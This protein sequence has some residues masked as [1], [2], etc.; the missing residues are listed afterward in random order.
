MLSLIIGIVLVSIA[1]ISKAIMDKLQFHYHKC[2]FKI[3]PVK[4]DQKF[5]DPTLSWE[6][7]YKEGSMIEPKFLGSTTYFVFLTDAWHFFQMIMLLS[8]FIGISLTAYYSGSIIYMIIKVIVL[9]SFFG[10]S[11]SIFFNKILNV[12][13]I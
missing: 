8:L 2:I 7:K 11:F 10:L 1:G 4:Y 3:N 9:R 6:N 12:K 5:W 13:T